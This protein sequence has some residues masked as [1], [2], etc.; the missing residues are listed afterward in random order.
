MW[1]ARN[2]VQN[3]EY[4]GGEKQERTYGAPARPLQTYLLVGVSSVFTHE[5]AEY[6]FFLIVVR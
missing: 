5:D 1:P 4:A 2:R 6:Y 3:F